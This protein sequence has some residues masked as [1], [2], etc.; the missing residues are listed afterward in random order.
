VK[1]WEFFYIFSSKDLHNSKNSC[2][3]AAD[4]VIL[5]HNLYAENVIYINFLYPKM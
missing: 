1:P 4:F 3:F 2:T 5:W